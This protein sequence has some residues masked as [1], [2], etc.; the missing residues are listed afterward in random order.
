MVYQWVVYPE[1]VVLQAWDK[2]I[3][4]AIDREKEIVKEAI[5]SDGQG[6]SLEHCVSRVVANYPVRIWL[7]ADTEC[8]LEPWFPVEG[9]SVKITGNSF[10]RINDSGMTMR[11]ASM[12]IV[13]LI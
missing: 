1:L 8:M 10:A 4:F 11:N 12:F 9:L 6:R 3:R 2:R 7:I 13:N 5:Q